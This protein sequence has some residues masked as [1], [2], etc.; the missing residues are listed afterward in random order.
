MAC[1]EAG[2]TD[3]IN[4]AAVAHIHHS[5]LIPPAITTLKS[6]SPSILRDYRSPVRTRACGIQ[7]RSNTNTDAFDI[8]DMAGAT[9]EIVFSVIMTLTNN[10]IYSFLLDVTANPCPNSEFRA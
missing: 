7:Y 5:I 10:H 6:Q 9:P 4:F 1:V 8:L 3:E 2:V